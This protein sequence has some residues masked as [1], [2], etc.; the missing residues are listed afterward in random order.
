M[1][2]FL[3]HNPAYRSILAAFDSGRDA[4]KTPEKEWVAKAWMELADAKVC[5]ATLHF[6]GIS[7]E[8][9]LMLVTRCW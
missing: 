7:I 2:V 3:E 4:S 6:L 5:T 8:L 9:V 1:K